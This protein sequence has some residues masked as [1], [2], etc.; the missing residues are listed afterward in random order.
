MY[1]EVGGSAVSSRPVSA[2]G[3]GSCDCLPHTAY[4]LL[5]RRHPRGTTCRSGARGTAD[6]SGHQLSATSHS[7]RSHGSGTRDPGFGIRDSEIR[8]SGF[9]IRDSDS[10]FGIR[11]RIRLG[12]SG[13][14]IRVSHHSPDVRQGPAHESMAPPLKPR[15]HDR[16]AR[17]LALLHVDTDGDRMAEAAK[18]GTSDRA[19]DSG[20]GS[21]F[22][23]GVRDPGSERSKLNPGPRVPDPGSRHEWL[24]RKRP[25]LPRVD[26]CRRSAARLSHERMETCHERGDLFRRGQRTRQQRELH[27]ASR[28]RI[29]G[30][31]HAIDGGSGRI[32]FQI[33]QCQRA[34]RARV[35]NRHRQLQRTLVHLARRAIRF[36]QMQPHVQHGRAAIALLQVR[37][38]RLHQPPEHERQRL[39]L[40]DRPFEIERLL[41]SFFRNG[42]APADAHLLRAPDTASPCPDGQGVPRDRR[43]AVPRDRRA[44]ADPNGGRWRADPGFGIG[45]RDP[46]FEFGVRVEFG[47]PSSASSESV[48]DRPSSAIGS[49]ATAA[50]SLPG[51]TIV[52][53]ARYRTSNRAAVRVPAIATRTRNPRSAAVR[54][55]SSAIV[56]A[57]QTTASGRSDPARSPWGCTPRF[58]E[59]TRAPPPPAHQAERLLSST[60]HRTQITSSL[61]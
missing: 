31:R 42:R 5:S 30:H 29:H 2:V 41:E 14:E 20:L 60:A 34:Q 45:I 39:E 48:N 25:G 8:D 1:T 10:G 9:G 56:R 61:S 55:S 47:V 28:R 23:I 43:T 32:R 49:G 57:R 58:A 7:S 19:R 51:S 3:S 15:S 52:S 27:D 40:L 54:R 24:H 50:A 6:T 37:L 13:F 12:I 22:G 17:W 33:E 36:D 38:E 53:P 26:H 59:R 16:D 46:G 11:A 44:F 18:C 21:G 35:A 4:C